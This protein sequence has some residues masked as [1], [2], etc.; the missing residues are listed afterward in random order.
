MQLISYNNFLLRYSRSYG[1]SWLFVLVMV[2]FKSRNQESEIY[3][4]LH[5]LY[6][7]I[8]V[9]DLGDY[10]KVFFFPDFILFMFT[11]RLSLIFIG[12]YPQTTNKY[13][14]NY[15]WAIKLSTVYDNLHSCLFLFWVCG[16]SFDCSHMFH[17]FS[18]HTRGKLVVPPPLWT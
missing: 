18:F 4:Y 2:L 3:K 14:M 17:L 12:I 6:H 11:P 10:W 7:L 15:Y 16:G 1:Y 5:V 8:L 13:W 9:T